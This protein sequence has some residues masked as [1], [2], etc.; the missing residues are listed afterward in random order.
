MC[1]GPEVGKRIHEVLGEE[2]TGTAG[3]RDYRD[4]G[5]GASSEE[6][7]YLRIHSQHAPVTILLLCMHLHL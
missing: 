1:K 5:W 7:T 3:R 2:G 6:R 4:T